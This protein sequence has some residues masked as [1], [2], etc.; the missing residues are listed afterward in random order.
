MKYRFAYKLVA[1][2]SLLF[3]ANL[4]IGYLQAAENPKPPEEIQK[5]NGPQEA[6]VDKV[7]RE[8]SNPLTSLWSLNN[9]I[10]FQSYSG[11]LSDGKQQVVWDFKPVMPIGFGKD[12]IWVNRPTIPVF[13]KQPYLNKQNETWDNKSGLGDIEYLGLIGKNLP[14]GLVLAGGLT[15][16]FP[17][18]TNE[19]LGNGK[20]QAGPALVAA[21]LDKKY[22]VGTL[23]QQWWS[24]AGQ[25]DRPST[26][27]TAMQLFYFLNFS[28]GWQVGGTP[29][30]S[31]D[32]EEDSENRFNVP[33]GLGVYKTLKL[34][35]LPI[36]L[37][38]EFQYSVIHEELFGRDYNIKFM[39]TPVIP[40]L[41]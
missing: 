24:F 15:T 31:A 25:Q 3:A 12:W 2:I 5:E 23:V 9:E 37:G 28:G 34:G 18:A 27:L 21:K 39:F 4:S 17:T 20:W 33:I 36:K 6:D 16:I 32:W 7:A 22:I 11:K 35:K 30:I 29:I 1:S 14:G 26:N 8:L 40:A 19:A 13:F 38:V 41:F 10:D